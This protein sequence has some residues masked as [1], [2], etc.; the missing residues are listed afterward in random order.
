MKK[1]A[2]N[3]I[4]FLICVTS[5]AFSCGFEKSV[6]VI[7]SALA[8]ASMIIYRNHKKIWLG[9]LFGYIALCIVMPKFI[10]FLPI[11]LYHSIWY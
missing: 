11:V 2:G 8:I 6:I 10:L 7:L 1:I 3:V 5:T 4:I 9:I